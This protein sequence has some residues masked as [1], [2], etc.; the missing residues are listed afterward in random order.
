MRLQRRL[1][2]A[3]TAALVV[4][5]IVL[6]P[7]R[8]AWHW[9]APPGMALGGIEGSV[10]NGSAL[11]ASAHGLYLRDIAWRW[12]PGRLFTGQWAYRIKGV[13]G[14][15]FVNTDIG[16]SPGGTVYV[17]KLRGSVPLLALESLVGVPGI[18]GTANVDMPALRLAGG[19]PVAADG[20]IEISGLVVPL[21][22]PTPLGRYRAEVQTRE[23]AIV[24]S[25][26]DDGAVVDL[27]GRLQ[28]G[29]DRDYDFLGYVAPTNSTPPPLLQQLKYLGTPNDRGQYE[30]R[31]SGRF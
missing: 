25:V 21:V 4:G 20:T 24:A 1:V 22:A 19:V 28:L 12:L 23:N 14:S 26:Q 16:V 13:P 2:I 30:L 5:L 3:G 6:F 11:E 31:L 18:Q 9:F 17:E 27:A 29:P 8:V 10:W 15:G 7:A